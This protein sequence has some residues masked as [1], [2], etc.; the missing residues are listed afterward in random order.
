MQNSVAVGAVLLIALISSVGCDPGSTV[1]PE[2]PNYV[3]LDPGTCETGQMLIGGQCETL[4]VVKVDTVGYLVGRAKR[5]TV[6]AADGQTTFELHRADSGE[7]VFSGELSEARA[8]EDTA[9]QVQIADFSG[10]DEPGS[11]VLAIDGVPDSPEFRIGE[12]TFDDA[13]ATTMLGFYG[14]RCGVEIDFD[15]G[16][17]EY[18]H[19]ACHLD[20]ADTSYL[21][22]LDGAPK[23]GTGGWHDAGDYGKYTVNGAFS[24]A[25][26]L[27]AWEDFGD[28]LGKIIYADVGQGDLPAWL[29][30]ARFEMDRLLKMQLDDGS[31]SHELGPAVLPP[32]PVEDTSTRASFPGMIMP[33]NDHAPPRAFARVSL[34]A[35][36]ALAAVAALAARV[37]QPF[38][39]DYAATCLD[40]AKLAQQYLDSGEVPELSLAGFTHDAYVGSFTDQR[41]W[42]DVELWRATGDADLRATVEEQMPTRVPFNWDWDHLGNLGVFDYAM[43]DDPERD[44]AVVEQV[45]SAIVASAD[46]LVTNAAEHG[47]GRGIG[48]MYY[49]GINGVM[50]RSVM[51]LFVANAI[52]PNP[53]Y[54]DTAVEQIDYLLGRNPFGRSM[55]TGV[56]FLPPQSPHH[57]PSVADGIRPPWPGLLVGGPNP[58]NDSGASQASAPAPGLSWF[59]NSGD[60]TT[61]EVAINWNAALAYAL[62]GFI[63]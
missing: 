47:Y 27:K 32:V 21:S 56:G 11:Y 3:P 38:D 36:A 10:F 13:L 12:D 28:V 26:L 1:D 40:A 35:T 49:W 42:A 18:H 2:D 60:Y 50:A 19:D 54:L 33:G 63:Q 24:V 25:M 6:P 17:V 4:T 23:D 61:N 53:T 14:Q 22:Q 34:N 44:P 55:L 58:N 5:A 51:N 37:Y 43:S 52:D 15:Y 8:N 62:A 59:D 30:E 9:E 46:Q 31:A 57:R 7:T 41:L 16:D 39:Q 29:E 48:S 45:N 20:D